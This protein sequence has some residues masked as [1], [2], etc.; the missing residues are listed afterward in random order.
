MWSDGSGIGDAAVNDGKWLQ[1]RLVPQHWLQ[2]D[3]SSTLRRSSS[4]HN[5]TACQETKSFWIMTSSL[6]ASAAVARLAS[7]TSRQPNWEI[8][9]FWL[10]FW[11]YYCVINRRVS[12]PVGRDPKVS[13]RGL[14]TGSLWKIFWLMENLF[15][16]YYLNSVILIIIYYTG[17]AAA[18]W[19]EGCGFD[20]QCG[21]FRCG[22]GPCPAGF[23]PGSPASPYSAKTF[24]RS[25][26][27]FRSAASSS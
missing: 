25:I 7:F 5:T 2:A 6:N 14:F 26:G 11:I 22:V 8:M 23:S 27:D 15:C 18:S 20:S 13:H 10:L 4:T 3:W 21:T 24:S 16:S 1:L 17:S 19:Q 9:L 12:Q